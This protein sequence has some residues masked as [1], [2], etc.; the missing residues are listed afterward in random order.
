M[1]MFPHTITLYNVET[2]TDDEMRDVSKNN[3]TILCG[4]LA[5]ESKAVNVRESGLTGADAVNLYIP[6]DV[7]AIDGSESKSGQPKQKKFV[8]PV[9]FWNADDKTGLWTLSS[10]IFKAGKEGEISC[11]CHFI[12]GVAVHF[13]ESIKDLEKRYGGN[14][15]DITTVDTKDFG[16]LQHWEVGGK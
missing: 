1:S 14:A 15:Y 9:E 5:D 7:V 4:V 12:K 2:F 11:T 6:F 3:I 8:P 13:D 10:G 16:G